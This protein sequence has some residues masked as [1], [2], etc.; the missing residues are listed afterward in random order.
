MAFT[1]KPKPDVREVYLVRQIQ[2]RNSAGELY[3]AQPGDRLV[4]PPVEAK[5][6]VQS[7]RAAYVED[8]QVPEEAVSEAQDYADRRE[9]L[10]IEK[11]EAIEERKAKLSAHRAAKPGPKRGRSAE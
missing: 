5:E 9:L 10:H 4:L 6:L 2:L 1:N 7:N 11:A 3:W 8:G